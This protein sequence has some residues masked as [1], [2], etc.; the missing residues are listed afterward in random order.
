MAGTLEGYRNDLTCN[1]SIAAWQ[2]SALSFAT[3]TPLPAA[4]P[5]ALTTSAGNFALNSTSVNYISHA[6]S[7][8]VHDAY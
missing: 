6:A 3:I 2:A 7:S 1:M 5:L 8:T 4:K